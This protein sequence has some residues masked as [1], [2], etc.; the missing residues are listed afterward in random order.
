VSALI[1]VFLAG[2]GKNELGG[3][4]GPPAFH[5]P[6]KRGALEALLLRVRANGWEIGGAREWKSYRKFRARG[7]IDAE[8]HAVVGA[9]LDAREAECHVLAFCRDQ[10]KDEDRNTAIAK[11]MQCAGD[12]P[13]LIGGVAIPTLEGWILGLLAEEKTES[14]SPKQAA[15]RLVELGVPEKDT[16]A[17]VAVIENAEMNKVPA[18]A[19]SLRNWLLQARTAMS[20]L[21]P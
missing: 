18:D 7:V 8:A 9:A 20:D 4:I 3:R 1:R 15:K 17:M 16:D 10:D 12:S 19:E 11:G 5:K 6:E 13:R 14:L 2:E 21:A